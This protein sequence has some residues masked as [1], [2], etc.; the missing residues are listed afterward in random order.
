MKRN[1][2]PHAVLFT[3][4]IALGLALSACG[5][6]IK[7]Y[8]RHPAPV[9]FNNAQTPPV[10]VTNNTSRDTP[11]VTPVKVRMQLKEYVDPQGGSSYTWEP[12]PE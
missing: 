4:C 8:H 6:T 9:V 10:V 12:V 7:H 3:G 1:T 2:L 5:T 11:R